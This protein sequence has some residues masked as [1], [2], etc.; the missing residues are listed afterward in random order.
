[1]H[2][3]FQT[4]TPSSKNGGIGSDGDSEGALHASKGAVKDAVQSVALVSII[5]A[6][7]HLPL[8]KNTSQR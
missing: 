7:A 5:A 2:S 8:N 1:M 3:P 4:S 6:V